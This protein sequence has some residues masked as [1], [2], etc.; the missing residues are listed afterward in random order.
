[1]T[2]LDKLLCDCGIGS[3]SQVREIIRSGRVTV[4]GSAVR[5]PEY[6]LDEKASAV[7]LDGAPVG[8]AGPVY[9]MLNKPAG[10]ITATE[11]PRQKTVLDLLPPEYRR[12]GV[13]PAGRLDKD[14]EGLLILTNDGAAAH[15]LCSPRRHAEKVYF[16]RVQGL[17]TPEDEAA[18]QNGLVL[19]DGQPCRPAGLEILKADGVSEAHVT[20]SEGKY[21]QVKRMF[22]SRGKTVVY[23]KRLAMG[24]ITLDESLKPGG[25]RPLRSG[26]IGQIGKLG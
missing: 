7:E 3:R 14:T 26:E 20:I 24:G 17:L 15:A 22:A 16:A 1:M 12:M 8:S 18:F 25:F 19:G 2:R 9:L 21:H 11:D 13:F 10:V 23:L 6:K 5:A 4:N